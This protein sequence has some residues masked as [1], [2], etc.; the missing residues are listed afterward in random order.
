MNRMAGRMTKL[1]TVLASMFHCWSGI[2]QMN[3]LKNVIFFLDV[4]FDVS[5]YCRNSILIFCDLLWHSV[6]WWRPYLV[7]RCISCECCKILCLGYTSSLMLQ[8]PV[9]CLHSI[10]WRRVPYFGYTL[11]DAPESHIWARLYQMLQN[12]V[13][14]LHS[15]WARDSRLPVTL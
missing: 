8:N 1:Y 4:A 5:T 14:R 9:V 2:S 13:Y 6:V 7:R 15:D 10:R 3:C 12:C 11:I